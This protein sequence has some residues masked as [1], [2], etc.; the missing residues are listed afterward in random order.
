M[1][2]KHNRTK[3]QIQNSITHWKHDHKLLNLF[4]GEEEEVGRVFNTDGCDICNMKCET[5]PLPTPHEEDG[6]YGLCGCVADGAP[7]RLA[8]N[9]FRNQDKKEF[10]KQRWRIIKRLQRALTKMEKEDVEQ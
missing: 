10:Q 6:R 4:G 2:K 7:F 3:E 9:A 5:C 1:K 8:C